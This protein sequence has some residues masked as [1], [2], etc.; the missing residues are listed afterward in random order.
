MS[1][2]FWGGGVIRIKSIF[3]S[4]NKLSLA[5]SGKCVYILVMK[6]M[7]P[8]VQMPC[9]DMSFPVVYSASP[10]QLNTRSEGNLINHT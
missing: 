8:D 3:H 9:L 4:A 7:Y 1:I 10:S 6:L 2:F 5:F